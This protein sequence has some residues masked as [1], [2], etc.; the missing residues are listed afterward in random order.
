[1]GEGSPEVSKIRLLFQNLCRVFEKQ[2]TKKAVLGVREDEGGEASEG[3]LL[4]EREC[5][6]VEALFCKAH[7]IME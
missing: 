2:G 5:V 4:I 3:D 7:D 6:Q 1:M